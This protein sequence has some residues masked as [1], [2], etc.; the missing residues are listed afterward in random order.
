MSLLRALGLVRRAESI[1]EPE[2]EPAE[3]ADPGRAVFQ[4]AV[5]LLEEFHQLRIVITNINTR[6]I[7]IA[8]A[9][10]LDLPFRVR[11][12]APTLKRNCWAR[13]VSQHDGVAELELPAEDD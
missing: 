7:R 5:L 11:L 9:A 3:P 13:V 2:A 4:E 6:G 1:V 10:R 12:M 8:Y